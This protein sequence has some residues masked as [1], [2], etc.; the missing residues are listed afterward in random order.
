M[1]VAEIVAVGSLV[2]D[3][4]EG[5]ERTLVPGR[6]KVRPKHLVERIG[7]ASGWRVRRFADVVGVRGL[8]R[9]RR[10]S[11]R[12]QPAAPGNM[13]I[14]LEHLVRVI[15]SVADTERRAGRAAEE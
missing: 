13:V 10:E 12:A 8:Q 15:G 14:Q 7:R 6:V 5:R 4:Q 3:I 9:T 1:L 2:P 11:R